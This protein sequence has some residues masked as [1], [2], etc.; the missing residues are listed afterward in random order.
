MGA[1]G[2]LPIPSLTA[3]DA[4]WSIQL[5]S[6]SR[7]TK[8][9]LGCAAQAGSGPMSR[10]CQAKPKPKPFP[11]MRGWEIPSTPSSSLQ[12]RMKRLPGQWLPHIPFPSP[13]QKTQKQILGFANNGGRDSAPGRR[14]RS[15]RRRNMS[16]VEKDCTEYDGGQRSSARPSLCSCIV[17]LGLACWRRCG[18]GSRILPFL[19]LRRLLRLWL[20]SPTPGTEY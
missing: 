12:Q 18:L 19:L 10:V 8:V 5:D 16:P 1:S 11:A 2:K 13:Y 17:C 4:H 15:L 3:G 6:T 14:L 7:S 9:T 20:C